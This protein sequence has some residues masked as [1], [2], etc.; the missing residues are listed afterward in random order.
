[1]DTSSPFNLAEIPFLTSEISVNSRGWIDSSSAKAIT[2]C[3]YGWFEDDSRPAAKAITISL[4][5]PLEM[6]TLPMAGLPEVRVP[7]LS[8]KTRFTFDNDSITSPPLAIAPD[9]D[10]RERLAACGTGEANSRA[11]G[12]ATTHNRRMIFQSAPGII[13]HARGAP[14]RTSGT[15]IEVKCCSA[16]CNR[17]GLSL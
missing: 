12:Q 8:S 10:A 2:A 3:A 5:L 7:V 15:Q 1:M 14:I 11:Q 17:V 9:F 6:V 4:R 13:N 16:P